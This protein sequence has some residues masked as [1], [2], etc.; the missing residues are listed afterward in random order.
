MFLYMVQVGEIDKSFTF[1]NG[2]VF[3]RDHFGCATDPNLGNSLGHPP[4]Y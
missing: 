4:G 3:I 1:S 2:R